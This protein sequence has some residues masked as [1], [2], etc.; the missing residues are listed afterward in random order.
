MSGLDTLVTGEGA[1]HTFLQAE[2]LK[3]NLIYAGHY[4]TET[5]GVQAL[6]AHVSRRFEIPWEFADHPTGM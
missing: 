4:A 5:I 3:L 1:H 6:A 2:E